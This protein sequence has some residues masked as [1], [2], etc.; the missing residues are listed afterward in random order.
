MAKEGWGRDKGYKPGHHS[1]AGM[2]LHQ[3]GQHHTA[4]EARS[5][6]ADKGHNTHPERISVNPMNRHR[7]RDEDLAGINVQ[8]GHDP[9]PAHFHKNSGTS[10]EGHALIRRGR[11]KVERHR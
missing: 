1:D 7:R 4:F 9:R 6:R 2:G 11:S 8:G 3:P 10:P 5:F